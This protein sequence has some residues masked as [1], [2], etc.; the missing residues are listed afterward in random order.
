MIAHRA[1]S[2]IVQVPSL[3]RDYHAF[4]RARRAARKHEAMHV[5]LIQRWNLTSE[6]AQSVVLHPN[7]GEREH[8]VARAVDAGAEPRGVG[9]VQVHVA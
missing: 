2:I 9:V 8:C 1:A 6:F 5:A 4:G 3:L 7:A